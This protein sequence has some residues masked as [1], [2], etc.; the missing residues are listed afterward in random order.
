[1]ASRNTVTES[2]YPCQEPLN[3]SRREIR[4]LTL[5]PDQ[6]D[7][8]IRA[9]LS[10]VSL[11]DEP[12]MKQYHT[13]GAIPGAQSQFSSTKLSF[14]SPSILKKLCAISG[15]RATAESCGQ[16][17]F[18]SSRMTSQRKILRSD[19]WARSI[20]A[21]PNVWFGLGR[22]IRMMEMQHST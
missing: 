8:P 5:L 2:E 9:T 18:V 16:T 12:A 15:S 17:Q 10:T 14:L 22:W 20:P 7:S 13:S 1:M 6:S 11:L 4:L 21:A 19:V 3:A